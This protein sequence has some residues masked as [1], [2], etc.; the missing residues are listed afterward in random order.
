MRRSGDRDDGEKRFI[1]N[2]ERLVRE[3]LRSGELKA[4]SRTGGRPDELGGVVPPSLG[5]ASNIDIILQAAEEIQPD[6]PQVARILCE[7]AYSMA[8]T[9]DPQSEGRGVLQFKTGLMSVIRQKQSKK[10]GERID[11][12]HDIQR[13]QEFYELYRAKHQIDE[14]ERLQKVPNFEEDPGELE[15]RTQK[16]KKVYQTS[17]V[18]NDV[19]NALTRDATPEEREKLI[20]KEWKDRME[21]DA[22][23]TLDFKA[24]NILPLETPGVAD[25]IMLFEEVEA[26]ASFLK[27]TDNLPQ[28]PDDYRLPTQR[29][30]DIFDLLEYIFGFQDG[31]V[32]NQRENLVL[33]LSNSQSMLGLPINSLTLDEEAVNRCFERLLDNYIKWCEYLRIPSMTARADTSQRKLLLMAMYLLIW[34]E[35]ANLRFLPECLC[36]IFHQMVDELYGFLAL[37]DVQRSKTWRPHEGKQYSYLE[38]VVTPVYQTLLAESKNGGKESHA[39]WRNYDDFNEFFWSPRCFVLQWPW[40]TDAGFFMKP[41]KKGVAPVED[42]KVE[43]TEAGRK[44]EKRVG[45]MTFVEH[46][47]ALHVYHS[48]HRLWIFFTVMLQAMMVVAFCNEKINARTFKKALSVGPTYL[49]MKTVQSL[50]D[51]LFIYGAYAS[52]QG[53][54]FSRI[55]VRLLFYGGLGGG[56]TFLYVKMI[57]EDSAGSGTTW[58][59]LY[60]I[61]LGSYAGFQLLVTALMRIPIF[62]RQADKCSNW[63]IIRFIFWL[64]QDRY[65]VGRGLYERTRDY[66]QYTVFWVFVLACKFAFSYHF[67]IRSLVSPTKTIVNLGSN[68]LPYKWH[69]FVSRRHH[70]ALTIASLWAPVIMIYYLDTQVWYTIVSALVGGL[71]G[72][73]ARLGEIRTL[74]MLRKRFSTFPGEMAR[75]LVPSR[76]QTQ[77]LNRSQSAAS[78]Q[79]GWSKAKVDAFKFAPLWNEIVLSLRQEDYISDGEKKLL[80]MPSNVDSSTN[81]VQWPLFLLA[82]KVYMAVEMAQDNKSINQ[83]QLWERIEKDEYMAYAVAEAYNLLETVL[84]SLVNDEAKTWVRSVFGDVEGALQE[85]MLVGHFHLRQVNLV[86]LRVQALTGILTAPENDTRKRAAVKAMQD[87]YETVM[88]DFLSVELREKFESWTLLAQAKNDGRLFAN[89]NW[90]TSPEEKEAVTRLNLLL[91]I[92]ESSAN[93]PHNL[94]ARRRLEFFTNSLFMHMPVAPPVRK[95]LSFSVFTP[96]YEEDVMYS[97]Q[98]LVKENEDGISILFYL[99]KIFPDEWRNFLERVE[100][101]ENEMGRQLEN[102]KLDMI[103]LRLWASFRGQTLART[104]RGMMYYKKALILSNLLEAPATADIEE[105]LLS[106][107]GAGETNPGFRRARALAELKFTY[108]V[109]CQIYGQQ[110]QRKDL[111]AADISYLMRKYESLRIA[112]IDVVESLKDEK[113]T[114][115]YYSKL[116]KADAD[117]NDQE[118]YSIKLPGEFRL[119]EGK[120][121]NQ[122][123]AIV[124]TRGDAIQTIDMNQDNYFEEAFKMRNLL[125]EFKDTN[126]LRRP[127]ILGIREHV[128]TGSVSSLAWFMSQQETSFVTLG[129]RVLAHPLKVRMHYGHPDVFDRI[130]H[131]TRGGISKASRTINISEDIYAGFNSTLRQGNVTHHEYIQVGKGRDVGLNQIATFEAKVSSGNGEQILSRDVFRL[132]QLFDFWRMLSFFYTSVGYYITTLMTTLV[133]YLFL[134]G[135]CYLALSGLD[136]QLHNV[137]NISGNAALNSALNTQFLFQIGVFTAVPMIMNFILEQGVL[138]AIISFITMQLQLASVFFTF[139]LGTKTHYFGRTVLHGGAKYRPT[140]RGFVV[141][142]IS[143]GENYRLYS[144]SHFTKALEIAMLLIVYLAY[145]QDNSGVTY[146]LL[147]ISSWFLALSWLFAPYIFNPSGFEWQKTVED[148]DDWTNWLFYKGG[149]SVKGEDSWESWWEEEQAHIR[150]L[151]GRILEI[152]LSLRFFFFQYGVVYSLHVSGHSTSLAV[153]GYSWVVFIGFILLF[154]VF[155]F[156]NQSSVNFQL[157]LRLFQGVLF[158][159]IV[160]AIVVCVVF[161]SLTVGDCFA[162]ILAFIPTGWGLLS[163]ALAL[164]PVLEP[165]HLYDIVRSGFRLYDAMMGAVIFTPIAILSWFPFVSTFQTRLVFNQAFSRGLEISLILAGNRPNVNV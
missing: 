126:C 100:L 82:N 30:V 91:T 67:M 137:A 144:R 9:L 19:L 94:E 6:D 65:F 119:G 44:K 108:V 131:I 129:Q 11:R 109:T 7:Y 63:S 22:K 104:V 120:P 89:L 122:N 96:Y 102:E 92:K 99:Q 41:R 47:T 57:Q 86:L 71:S 8:H 157:F 155:T 4:G 10:E 75:T 125:E 93:I 72:A 136:H 50:L 151:R 27:H 20:Q 61:V 160:A 128:F 69:D 62:R 133:V 43:A 149:I 95:M 115:T 161:T 148:F 79:A 112:Y 114:T 70:N 15:R 103:E 56:V 18:L 5:Q 33:L 124:F 159:A 110:K 48:F 36:Y 146:V 156:T 68:Q 140:G 165:L 81:M 26:A 46:R 106:F 42:G 37:R 118:I 39:A 58:Y 113:N 23:K 28:F 117:G 158:L 73:R 2:W 152:I 123:H 101:T 139:S 163:I 143:F 55:F 17:R 97:K 45:K 59:N 13:I 25:A 88:H 98:Q 138:K 60:L 29:P 105:G 51:L 64:H 80:V 49:I 34:G 132:G 12:T 141:R 14:L 150:S 52:T 66:L 35:A 85:S 107:A 135:K 53:W 153:Y 16:L 154:K 164:R 78:G 84:K 134:Y 76:I 3:A 83:I 38:Q 127:T 54:T 74:S 32:N 145:G 130:F 162:I 90:P 21:T 147:S 31:N 116:I 1:R 111:R 77:Q 24:Y 87:L 40:R 121:E 142:H